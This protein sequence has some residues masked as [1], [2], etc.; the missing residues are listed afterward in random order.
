M[1]IRALMK[2]G[3]LALL[4]LLFV[5]ATSQAATW[6]LITPQRVH[7]L[8]KEGSG[9]WL[10]DVRNPVAFEQGHIEGAVNIPYDQLKLKNLP[11]SKTLVLADD[12]LG[13]R[14]ARAAAE[15]LVK[16]GYEKVFIMEGG[17]TAWEGEKFPTTGARIEILR[18]VPWDDLMWAQSASIPHKLYDLRDDDE[19]AKGPVKGA[20]SLKGKTL[21]ER[22]KA[23]VAE[24]TPQIRKN[25]LAGKLERSVPIVLV[26]PNAHRPL[27]AVRAA[28]KG[29]Q[30]D[31]RYLE[32]AY[33]LWVARE[34][35]NP[36]PGPEVCPTCPSGKKVTK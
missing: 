24:L 20:V 28:V 22:L 15:I 17:I 13:L 29:I 26:L 27:D 30:G 32:G 31:I 18:P 34:K 4:C 36:L 25:G 5:A 10:I 8:V 2:H 6:Q 19:K 11:K 23:L 33:P 14:H 7:G 12:A 35:Q 1:K 16:K 9:L 21:E 3:T